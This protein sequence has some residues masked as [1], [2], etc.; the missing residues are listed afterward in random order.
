MRARKVARRGESTMRRS[1]ETFAVSVSGISSFRLQFNWKF[2]LYSYIMQIKLKQK[3]N[4][5]LLPLYIAAT[6]FGFCLCFRGASSF[7]LISTLSDL[8]VTGSWPWICTANGKRSSQP[9]TKRH[10]F[11]SSNGRKITNTKLPMNNFLFMTTVCFLYTSRMW[12]FFL[13][14]TVLNRVTKPA[15]SSAFQCQR[16]K[17]EEGKVC[18]DT[19]KKKL[20]Y[21]HFMSCFIK[22]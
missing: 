9:N 16:K 17:K 22:L 5:Q 11:A 6:R 19:A 12:S 2:N 20:F 10:A 3:K 1:F 21:L 4:T 7:G 8:H 15:R 18:E 14:P 13:I